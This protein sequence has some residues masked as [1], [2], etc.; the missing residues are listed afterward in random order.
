LA[1]KRS[2]TDQEILLAA[3]VQSVLGKL[4]NYLSHMEESMTGHMSING[5]LLKVRE[6]KYKGE[7]VVAQAESGGR[8]SVFLLFRCF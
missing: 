4:P 2:R 8:E 7:H 1:K 6:G 5:V 3:L